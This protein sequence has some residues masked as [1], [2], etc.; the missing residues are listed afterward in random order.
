MIRLSHGYFQGGGTN[1][2]AIIT[3]NRRTCCLLARFNR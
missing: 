3:D 1:S 2:T